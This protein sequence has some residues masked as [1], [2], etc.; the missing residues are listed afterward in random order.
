MQTSKTILLIC[1]SFPPYPG[2]GG[3]RWAKFAKYL[4]RCGHKIK[5]IASENPFEKKS[6]WLNDVKGLEVTCLPFHYPY[7]L[8]KESLSFPEKIA[9]RFALA[10][11]KASGKGNYHDRSLFWKDQ[12]LRTASKIIAD[13]NIKNVIVTCPPFHMAHHCLELK[14]KF[15]GIK[16]I[17]DMRD[18]WTSDYSLSPLGSMS[19]KRR[20]DEISMEKEVLKRS[21]LVLAVSENMIREFKKAEPSCNC[22]VLMN[23]FDEDDFPG[24]ITSQSNTGDKMEL[25]FTGT[26]YRNLEHLF[27]PLVNALK[28]MRSEFP[29][30]YK[31]FSFNF[32]GSVPDEIRSMCSDEN[33]VKFHGPVS[34]NEVYKKIS[35]AGLCMLFLSEAYTFSL[36]TKF[37][38]YISQ[39][40]KI[41]L[42]SNK[43]ETSEFIISHNL[44]YWISPENMFEGL[45]KL[46]ESKKSGDIYKWK[47]TLDIDDFSVN[48][49]TKQLEAFLS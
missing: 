16:L 46:N 43:G 21:D 23:G 48:T 15:K 2:I 9:Y 41:V 14:N 13:N 17:T 45:M 49:L 25:V 47:T 27:A 26:L 7:V 42:F 12:V 28:K 4:H 22:H 40:K 5:V 19:E 31:N 3:R 6:E 24:G 18:L 39:K 20:K 10:Y 36:S 1:H 30:V 35:G 11:V 44:G 8:K 29:E 37:C 32:Y 34:L 38:E 33:A